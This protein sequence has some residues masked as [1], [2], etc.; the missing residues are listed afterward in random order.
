MFGFNR[1]GVVGFVVVWR[2][3][4]ERSRAPSNRRLHL[5]RAPLG[6]G[7]YIVFSHGQRFGRAQNRARALPRR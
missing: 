7:P 5:T 6:V 3:I 2:S 4:L 1:P